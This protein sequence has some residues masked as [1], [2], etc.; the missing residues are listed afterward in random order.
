MEYRD[1]TGG[2]IMSEDKPKLF[3]LDL[4]SGIILG[5]LALD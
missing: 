5:D 1:S 3:V 4:F 2:K